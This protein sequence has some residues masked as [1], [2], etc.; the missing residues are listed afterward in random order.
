LVALF[1]EKSLQA[2]FGVSQHYR[3][4]SDIAALANVR[5]ENRSGARE[6]RAVDAYIFCE[7]LTEA[8]SN[9]AYPLAEAGKLR[10]ATD[11]SFR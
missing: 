5:F 4:F 1:A 7:L 10:A 2:I 9:S 11:W 3:H 6:H 8:G